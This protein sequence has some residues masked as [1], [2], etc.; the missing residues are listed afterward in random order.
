MHDTWSHHET[1]IV[2]LK[3][4]VT[5]EISNLHIDLHKEIPHLEDEPHVQKMFSRI[6]DHKKNLFES[7]SDLRSLLEKEAAKAAKKSVA[8]AKTTVAESEEDDQ[9]FIDA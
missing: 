3:D 6:E 2:N 5:R 1:M 7:L 9:D 4:W 8:D